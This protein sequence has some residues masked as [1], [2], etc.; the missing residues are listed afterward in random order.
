MICNIYNNIIVAMSF[1]PCRYMVVLFC[2]FQS[3]HF[4][5]IFLLEYKINIIFIF[6]IYKKILINI[7]YIKSLYLIITN[8][9]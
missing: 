3:N 1:T 5:F 4:F 6:L 8:K 7:I 2:V 9:I